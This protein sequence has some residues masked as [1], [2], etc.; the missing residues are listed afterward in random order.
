MVKRS[1]AAPSQVQVQP[2]CSTTSAAKQR[3]HKRS[4]A[5]PPQAQPS[6]ATTSA[7]KRLHHKRSQAT[8]P[9]AQPS[10]ST[11]SAAKLLRRKRSHTAPTLNSTQD[12]DYMWIIVD[13]RL[14]VSYYFISHSSLLLVSQRSVGSPLF[15]HRSQGSTAFKRICH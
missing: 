10:R 1:R 3:H 14:T 15:H 11:T 2:S 7:A 8:S 9:Q 13:K 5:A 6:N 12:C 4:Q